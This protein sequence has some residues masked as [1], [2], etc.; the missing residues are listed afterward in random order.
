MTTE[1]KAKA[2]DEAVKKVKDYYE[3]KTKLYSDVEQTLDLLFPELKE[4]EDEKMMKCVKYAVDYLFESKKEKYICDTCKDK[5]VAWLEKQ[6]EQHPTSPKWKYK[7]DNTPLLRDSIILNK[8]GCVAK[9]PSGAIVSDVWVLDYDELAKLPKEE[10]E[11]Q[12]EQSNNVEPKFKVGDWVVRGKTIAQILDIQEQYYVGLDIDGNDFTSNRFLS[13]DK[14][15]LWTIQDAKDGD[16]LCYEDEV[17]LYKHDIKNCTLKETSFGGMVYYCCYDGKRFITNSMYS[18]TERDKDYIHPATREQRDLLFSKMKKAGYEWDE[19]KKELREIEKQDEQKST[20]IKIHKGDKDNPYDMSFEEAQS[21]ITERNF[22]VCNL[23]CPVY[24]DERYILQTI[25]NILRWADDNPKQNLQIMLK[26]KFKVG[27]CITD[28][29]IYCK[30]TDILEDR[31]IV[32]TKFAKR[33]AIPFKC[34]NN[35]HL[36]SIQDA[37]DGDI[38]VYGKDKRPFIFKK[39]LNKF[40]PTYPVAYCGIDETNAFFIP[41]WCGLWTKEET[42]PAVKEQRDLLFQKMKE[43]GYEWDEEKKELKKIEGNNIPADSR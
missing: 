13:D 32:D 10:L 41:I 35:Y 5:V 7:K 1:E 12:G 30:V 37:M 3:G 38:L 14:I 40:H 36:W 4:S 39:L 19:D 29:Y 16:V 31:Y 2:Y 28:G 22:D 23:D 15:H 26:K 42:Q 9:S 20:E 6:G 8:Y 27:D 18:L 33:S 17:F 34:E 43:A 24:V 21:Y 11:K 25:G